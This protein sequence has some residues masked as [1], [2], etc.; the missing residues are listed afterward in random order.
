MER[1][2]IEQPSRI[3]LTQESNA[4]PVTYCDSQ[5][6][7]RTVL[8]FYCDSDLLPFAYATAH[9]CVRTDRQ[10]QLYIDGM[11]GSAVGPILSPLLNIFCI[12][13]NPKGMQ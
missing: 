11:T 8:D 5:A 10:G 2:R 4:L 13:P 3:D 9:A 1:G 6:S 7:L 12:L